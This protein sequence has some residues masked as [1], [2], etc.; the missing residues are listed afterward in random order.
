MA[1]CEVLLISARAEPLKVRARSMKEVTDAFRQHIR[2]S[3]GAM[4]AETVTLVNSATNDEV[5]QTG[6]AD[7]ALGGRSA[8]LLAWGGLENCHY[9]CSSA[10]RAHMVQSG[11]IQK[12]QRLHMTHGSLS[13]SEWEKVLKVAK[14]PLPPEAAHALWTALVGEEKLYMETDVFEGFLFQHLRATRRT[15]LHA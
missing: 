6:P 10:M 13:L 14:P 8:T 2:D 15:F 3:S 12:W 1:Q 11:G 9:E 5:L 7:R 4:T